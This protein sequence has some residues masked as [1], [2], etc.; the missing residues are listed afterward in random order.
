MIKR[1]ISHGAKTEDG[2]FALSLF[3]TLFRTIGMRGLLDPIAAAREFLRTGK[4]PDG[5][6]T[7]AAPTG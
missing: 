3:A 6:D 7:T 4:L 5:P 1:K 2:A